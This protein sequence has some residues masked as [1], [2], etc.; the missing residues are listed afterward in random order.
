MRWPCRRLCQTEAWLT[1]TSLHGLSTHVAFRWVL[2]VA[3]HPQ[4][5]GCQEQ[6]RGKDACL[7]GPGGPGDVPAAVTTPTSAAPSALLVSHALLVPS[8]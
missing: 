2:G 7:P 3:P 6:S 8:R 4:A 5:A 1:V